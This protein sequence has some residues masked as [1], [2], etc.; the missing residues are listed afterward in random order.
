VPNL[1]ADALS[2]KPKKPDPIQVK[3]A[4]AL[5]LAGKKDEAKA[6]LDEILKRDPESPEAKAARAE[7]Q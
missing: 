2:L 4:K 5:G 6:V 1:I 7:I 3:E